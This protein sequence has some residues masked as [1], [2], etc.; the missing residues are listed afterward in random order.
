MTR[1]AIL[2]IDCAATNSAINRILHQHP[3]EIALV[4]TSD[5]YRPARGGPTR[6][7]ARMLSRAGA[8]FVAYLGYTFHGYQLAMTTDRV[9][10]TLW[11]TPRR[12][13]SVA[14]TCDELSI[15][16]ATTTNINNLDTRKLLSDA[17][18]DLIIVFW[19]DQV[20]RQPVIN[21]PRRGVINIHA[22]T[23]PHC[24]GLFPVLHTAAENGPPFGLTAH[25]IDDETIDAG[26]V[27]AQTTVPAPDSA[28]ILLLDALINEYG[29]DLL[30]NI[31]LDPDSALRDALPQ[32]SDQGSYHS[33]PTRDDITA[34]RRTGRRLATLSDFTAVVRGRSRLRGATESPAAATGGYMTA[35]QPALTKRPPG[36]ATEPSANGSPR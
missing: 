7:A 23:L 36:A 29:A 30:H 4:L 15:Q 22:A 10:R 20:L 9:R 3:G 26:P 18:L 27:L 12:R 32:H 13:L 16:H 31:L 17:D 6:Q 5:I 24:R 19:F 14:E 34:V 28:S 2:T 35:S 33:Y 11:G 8:A 25:L 21:I 1:C